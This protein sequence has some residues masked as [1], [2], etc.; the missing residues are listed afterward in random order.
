M[1]LLR[2]TQ[3]L[4]NRKGMCPSLTSHHK[5]LKV[6]VRSKGYSSFITYDLTWAIRIQRS[7][8]LHIKDLFIIKKKLIADFDRVWRKRNGWIQ[9]S[10]ANSSYLRMSPSMVMLKASLCKAMNSDLE[11][12]N[13]VV[14]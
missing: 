6:Y 13:K 10:V 5:K 2:K 8:G 9:R 4:K 7:R 1:P 11:Q 14:K 12:T 3:Y